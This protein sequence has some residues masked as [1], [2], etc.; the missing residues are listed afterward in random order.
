LINVQGILKIDSVKITSCDPN[1]YAITNGSRTGSGV[2]IF[3]A[4]RPVIEVDTDATT[5][6][7]ITNW[8]I[9]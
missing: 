3:G 1:Y 9:A 2:F 6:S 5:P 7:E 8:E 4:P